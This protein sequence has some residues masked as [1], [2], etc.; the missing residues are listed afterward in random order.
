MYTLSPS[1]PAVT[2]QRLKCVAF[3]ILIVVLLS[4]HAPHERTPAGFRRR[5]EQSAVRRHQCVRCIEQVKRVL[6][7]QPPR[8]DPSHSFFSEELMGRVRSGLVNMFAPAPPPLSPLL[9]FLVSSHFAATQY[10]DTGPSLRA[11]SP[12]SDFLPLEQG[13]AARAL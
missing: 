8:R 4:L 2:T 11:F 12:P 5:L 13:G 9:P 6:V 10:L 3:L 7:R 1:N